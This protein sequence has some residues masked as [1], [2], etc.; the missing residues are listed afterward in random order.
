M[1]NREGQRVAG[2][3]LKAYAVSGLVTESR[4]K[5]GGTVQHTVELDEPI[6]VF[7]RVADVLL[8]DETDL[9]SQQPIDTSA[10]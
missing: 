3:Y 5:Y 2:M 8:M 6:N 4:V 1:W 7:G 10:F 9:F